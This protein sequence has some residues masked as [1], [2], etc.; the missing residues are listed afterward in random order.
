MS[1]PCPG[2]KEPQLSAVR[3]GHAAGCGDKCFITHPAPGPACTVTQPLRKEGPCLGL[4]GR[5]GERDGA[6]AA[7]PPRASLEENN[8]RSLGR[9]R[10]VKHLTD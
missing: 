10:H 4:R 1:Q 7:G 8:G 6:C 5:W 9:H 2:V 3:P